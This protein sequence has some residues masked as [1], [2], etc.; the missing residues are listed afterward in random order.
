MA[1]DEN[2]ISLDCPTY[3]H[4]LSDF[5]YISHSTNLLI[6][7]FEHRITLC[8]KLVNDMIENNTRYP[9]GQGHSLIGV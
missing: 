2:Y 8:M 3:T 4:V 1:E 6:L 7:L 9:T 5:Q